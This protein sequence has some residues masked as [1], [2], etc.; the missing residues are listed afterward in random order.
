MV[1]IEQNRKSISFDHLGSAGDQVARNFK[2]DRP[3][4]REIHDQLKSGRKLNGQFARLCT[5]QDAVDISCRIAEQVG[6]VRS[7][8]HQA[9]LGRKASRWI[10]CG[11]SI[12]RYEA[13]DQLD[14]GVVWTGR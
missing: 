4:G 13:E 8:S 3:R 9:T 2:S 12:R 6:A 7:V 14:V 5:A 11:R 1:A 10:D